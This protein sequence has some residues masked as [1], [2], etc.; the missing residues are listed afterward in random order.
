MTIAII[1]FVA[2]LAGG[3]LCWF[4]ALTTER[5]RHTRRFEEMQQ[6][7]GVAEGK[8]RALEARLEEQR[9]QSDQRSDKAAEDFE[10]LRATLKT[11]TEAKVAAETKAAQI[12]EQLEEQKKFVM[13]ST[14]KLKDTFK[15]L[16]GDSLK[17]SSEQFLS[18]ANE[19][20]GKALSDAKGDLGKRQES[21]EGLVKP[22]AE[23]IKQFDG[24]VRTLETERQKAYTS[25]EEHLKSLKEDQTKL[26]KE[27]GNLV[28]ALRAPQV[29]GR[30]GEMTLRRVVEL[31]GLSEHCDFA[32]QVSVG[33][34]EGLLRPDLVVSLPSGRQIVVDAKV[35]LDAYL[36]AVAAESPEQREQHLS[37]HAEQVRAH[38]TRLGGK[39]YTER[40]P[41]AP[42]FVVM[43]IPGESFFAEAAHRD[44]ALI[45][46]GILK[47]V[48]PATP[49]TLI[50]LLKAV[51]Y[52][53]RQEQVAKGAAEISELGKQLYERLR[54][55]AEHLGNVGG[56]LEKATSD[57]NKA[58]SSIESRVLPTARRFKEL[59]IYSGREIPELPLIQTTPQP[60]TRPDLIDGH[61]V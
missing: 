37:R 48:I 51:A 30:W 41:Q 55:M 4:V 9:L 20:F 26:Q 57:F 5:A 23:S 6:Q 40:F 58:V 36:S 46:D 15:A 22:L 28:T 61:D 47:N 38:M 14:E 1:A 16:A 19:A 43:F 11:E 42:E 32:E 39:A 18:L 31:A 59:G 25:L 27:T 44:V 2:A 49:T 45:E 56:S 8:A 60:F 52:G 33:G 54:V 29:R 17:G 53:W 13:E 34:E 12:A 50:A 3:L 35:S 7:L 21:I 10:K 24:H